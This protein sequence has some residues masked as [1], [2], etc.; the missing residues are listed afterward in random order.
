MTTREQLIEALHNAKKNSLSVGECWNLMDAAADMLEADG[1]QVAWR[2]EAAK[3][4]RRKA[5]DQQAINERYL[6][7]VACYCYPLW[8]SKVR[9]LIRLA[10]DLER[11]QEST[12]FGLDVQA[13]QPAIQERKPMTD[14]QIDRA[15]CC[16]TL[17]DGHGLP[18]SSKYDYVTW[19]KKTHVRAFARA[20]EAAHGIGAKP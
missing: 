1:V 6:R 5:N 13:H 10:K 9:D 12:P 15:R 14:E 2:T 17:P 8:E 18:Q 19:N 16:A 3:W 11:K 7:H 4:L 20:I